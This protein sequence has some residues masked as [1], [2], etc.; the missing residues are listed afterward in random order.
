MSSPD[1]AELEH[2]IGFNGSNIDCLHS[3]PTDPNAIVYGVGKVVVIA[4]L[5]D[6]HNQTLL[7]GHDTPVSA[8]SL[9]PSGRFLASGQ[10]LSDHRDADQVVVWDLESRQALYRLSGVDGSIR[11]VC[12]SEDDRFLAATGNGNSVAIW[13]MQTGLVAQ[14][15]KCEKCSTLMWGTSSVADES[16]RTKLTRYTLLSFHFTSVKVHELQYDIRTMQY[17][18]NSSQVKFPSAG[19]SR[20]YTMA[21][22]GTDPDEIVCGTT[23]GELVVI[24]E[25]SRIYR[26]TL[27]VSSNGL[28]SVAVCDGALFAGSGDGTVRK[29]T[30]K[31]LYWTI[32][33]EVHVP[34]RVTCLSAA[35]SSDTVFVGSD[36]GCLYALDCGAMQTSVVSENPATPVN[37]VAFGDHSE[38]F[39]SVGDNG[40][41]RMWDLGDY[42]VSTRASVTNCAGTSLLVDG[43]ELIVGF[44]DG[45]MKGFSAGDGSCVWTV[46]RAH[47]GPVTSLAADSSFLFSGGNDG[48]VRFWAGASHKFVSQFHEHS[49]DVTGL[50]LD[51]TDKDLLH[52]CSL[53]RGQVSY[54]IKEGK[55]CAYHQNKEAGLTGIAQ[56]VDSETE[57]ITSTTDG[58]MLFWDCD[59]QDP[60]QAID[61]NARMRINCAVL[62]NSG[63]YVA[64]GCEDCTVRIWDVTNNELVGLCSGHS[65]SVVSIGWS[66][67]EKQ[68]VSCAG[69]GAICVWNF[70]LAK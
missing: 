25:K 22:R 53:D 24:N 5:S 10:E 59:E 16:R 61:C 33:S 4:D 1:A 43:N 2:V 23:A 63:R 18:L 65:C 48:A 8:L 17:I 51:R 6:P 20:Q 13:D 40:D 27:P 44:S 58:M 60:V 69:D 41:V 11:S 55:R 36:A 39:A 9:S 31:D 62:S 28:L 70:Y 21:C 15:F 34:G 54:S 38:S 7:R 3:H 50:A 66:P 32:T 52:S 49:K 35:V 47:R 19:L 30:G 29:L 68:L 56:R 57:L 37:C 14:F 67:D 12:F 45:S 64:G 26:A 46:P 42:S